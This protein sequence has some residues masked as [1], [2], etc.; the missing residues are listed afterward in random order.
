MMVDMADVGRGDQMPKQFALEAE[1]EDNNPKAARGEQARSV[2]GN[3]SRGAIQCMKSGKMD[4][5]RGWRSRWRG[6][7][8]QFVP[9]V[10]RLWGR[11]LFM[12]CLL[13]YG[14]LQSSLSAAESVGECLTDNDICG[15]SMLMYRDMV[16][17]HR[18]AP[19]STSTVARAHARFSLLPFVLKVY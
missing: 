18:A 4:A 8:P 10:C 17:A 19:L 3:A 9:G 2:E 7:R 16:R 14:S 11:R 12:S 1:S 15:Y 6:S 5:H 13:S